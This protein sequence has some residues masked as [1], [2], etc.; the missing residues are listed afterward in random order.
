MNKGKGSVKMY[1]LMNKTYMKR[2]NELEQ[3]GNE[4][5]QREECIKAQ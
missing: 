2:V 4:K 5:Q 1:E 3:E